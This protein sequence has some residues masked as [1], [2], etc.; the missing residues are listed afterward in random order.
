MAEFADSSAGWGTDG[1]ADSRSNRG[2]D[3]R[4]DGF[5]DRRASSGADSGTD[6]IAGCGTDGSAD[7]GA[8]GTDNCVDKCVC[9]VSYAE[10]GADSRAAAQEVDEPAAEDWAEGAAPACRHADRYAECGS[11]RRADCGADSRAA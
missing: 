1:F 8:G 5:A 11:S 10:C 7:S 3:R 4:P 9:V 2:A 6:G